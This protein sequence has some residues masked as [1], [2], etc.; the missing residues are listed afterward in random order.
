MTT[1]SRTGN[2]LRYNALSTIALNLIVYAAS[3]LFLY[4][5]LPSLSVGDW[6]YMLK[7]AVLGTTSITAGSL[8]GH[9]AALRGWIKE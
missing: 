6:G 9:Y 8:S 5:S 7:I 2:N 1:R 3:F 4:G